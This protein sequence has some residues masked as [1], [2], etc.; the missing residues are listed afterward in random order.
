MACPVL[1]T[2]RFVWVR[3]FE[4]KPSSCLLLPPT[5]TALFHTVD[6]LEEGEQRLLCT[7]ALLRI[8]FPEVEANLHSSA[9]SVSTCVYCLCKLRWPLEHTDLYDLH[10]YS[11]LGLA[12]WFPLFLLL[13]ALL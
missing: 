12:V 4:V 2:L 8:L 3:S 1:S 9:L 5:A 6:P 7:C 13:V 11:F 10:C